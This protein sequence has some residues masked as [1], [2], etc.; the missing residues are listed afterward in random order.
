MM[1]FAGAV[2]AVLGLPLFAGGIVRNNVKITLSG[3]AL[4]TGGILMNGVK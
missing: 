1:A 2:V 3:A 4:F